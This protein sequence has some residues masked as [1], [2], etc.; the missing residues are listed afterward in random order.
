MNHNF[1]VIDEQPT[2]ADFEIH[3][4]Y[5]IKA[6]ENNK[7]NSASINGNKIVLEAGD[8][9]GKIFYIS[10]V[11]GYSNKSKDH[12]FTIVNKKTGAAVHVQADQPIAKFN[13]WASRKTV[14]PEPY[15]YMKVEPGETFKW[16]IT[17]RFDA[18][19]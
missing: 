11:K 19:E 6:G 7:P 9:A 5:P 15:I 13:F 8:P 4:P 2:G 18:K 17:Y 12:R 14:C 16:T 10:D 1:F 3:F